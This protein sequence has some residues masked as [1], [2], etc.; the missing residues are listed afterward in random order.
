[1]RAPSEPRP[2][3]TLQGNLRESSAPSYVGMP[4]PLTCG[5]CIPYRATLTNREFVGMP[6]PSDLRPS[7]TLQGNIPE[8]S[9]PSG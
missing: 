4:T 6:A 5:P 7:H 3:H 8:S 1:M 9:A 2:M